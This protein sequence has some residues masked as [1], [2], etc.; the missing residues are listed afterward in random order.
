VNID[1]SP[2]P[3]QVFPTTLFVPWA[4]YMQT[5][6]GEHNIF[7]QDQVIEI[8]KDQPGENPDQIDLDEV[9]SMMDNTKTVNIEE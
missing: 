9:I 7:E 4:M 5:E 6:T 8:L 3:D 2:E 1:I